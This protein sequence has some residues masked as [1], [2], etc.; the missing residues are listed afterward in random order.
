[1]CKF[2]QSNA[3]QVA[4]IEVEEEE[5]HEKAVEGVPYTE[6]SPFS[7]LV[8]GQ[9]RITW[10]APIILWIVLELRDTCL[11]S[12]DAK[13]E[14]GH[15]SQRQIENGLIEGVKETARR[16]GVHPGV[17]EVAD[18]EQEVLVEEVKYE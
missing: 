10:N 2:Y 1:M 15:R 16:E 3:I 17:V 18:D 12:N 11:L 4:I 8:G 6:Q 13:Y 5:R 7:K 14:N 9:E